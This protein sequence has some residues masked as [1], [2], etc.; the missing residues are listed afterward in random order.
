[1]TKSLTNDSVLA[2]FRT[3]NLQNIY[4]VLG[5]NIGMGNVYFNDIVWC[6]PQFLYKNT[7][8]VL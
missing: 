5:P 3:R 2:D 8:L 1:M 6:C 4:D 7:G